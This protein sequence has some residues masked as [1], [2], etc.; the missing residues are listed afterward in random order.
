MKKLAIIAIALLTFQ[1]NAQHNKENRKEKIAK[2]QNMSAEDMAQIQTK[3]M[4][5]ALDLTEDQQKRVAVLN[6]KN[7]KTRK[8]KI[9]KMLKEREAQKKRTQED[10][11]KM[12]NERL[13]AKIAHKK[14]MKSILTEK[15]YEKWEKYEITKRHKKQ[16]RRK[17]GKKESYK[18][19]E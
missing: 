9:E 17:H 1:V 7:A 6:L 13:D 14:E 5:L 12:T 3:K 15:Q 4:T 2:I 10:R 11:V 16:K 8:A 19:Q 18:H